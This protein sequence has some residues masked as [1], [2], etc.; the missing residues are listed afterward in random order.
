GATGD[1]VDLGHAGVNVRLV[2]ALI[3][4]AH[5]DLEVAVPWPCEPSL[6]SARDPLESHHACEVRSGRLRRKLAAGGFDVAAAVQTNGRRKASAIE[7]CFER[8][9][10]GA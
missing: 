9:D 4:E 5:A 8:S 10:R 7:H 1:E 6:A 2:D 3:C